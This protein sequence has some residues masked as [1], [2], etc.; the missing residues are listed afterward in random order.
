MRKTK[1]FSFSTTSQLLFAINRKPNY[2]TMS[3]GHK[4]IEKRRQAE[5][6]YRAME[7]N[8]ANE[9]RAFEIATWENS[10]AARGEG[11]ARQ[12]RAKEI[13]Q[14]HAKQLL[15][16]KQQLANLYNEEMETWREAVMAKVETQEDRKARS[17]HVCVC[18]VLAGALFVTPLSSHHSES[19]KGRTRCATR[20]KL[21][22]ER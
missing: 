4:T 14:Q 2:P 11:K 6:R 10:S 3:L 22:G 17:V 18:L 12:D 1:T 19:W 9:K 20:G 16:R 21:S 8:L 7:A 13:E 15:R 5:D